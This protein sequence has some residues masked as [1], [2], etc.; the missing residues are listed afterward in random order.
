[1]FFMDSIIKSGDDVRLLSGGVVS[2]GLGSDKA[3]ARMFNRLTKNAVLDRRSP[4][5]GVE[6][7]VNDHREN[8]WNEWRATGGARPSSPLASTPSAL[9]PAGE[10]EVGERG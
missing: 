10:R 9:P 4:L 1:M 2:N 5:R 3:V 6:G 8:A 7:Q